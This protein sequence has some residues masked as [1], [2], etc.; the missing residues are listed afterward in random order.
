MNPLI[1]WYGYWLIGILVV[2][3]G[4]AAGLWPA[5]LLRSGLG[6]ARAGKPPI[7]M[8]LLKVIFIVLCLLT[9]LIWPYILMEVYKEL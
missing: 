2:G 4:L 8:W 1:F 7:P 9:T 6:R 5:F 3:I